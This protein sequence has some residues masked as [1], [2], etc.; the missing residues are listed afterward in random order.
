MA[1]SLFTHLLPED[2]ERYLEETARVLKPG[3]RFLATFYLMNAESQRLTES[4]SLRPMFRF[5]HDYGD[6]RL[7]HPEKPERA[8]AYRED[9]V[10]QRFGRSGY[11][12][13]EVRYGRWSARSQ[14]LSWQDV[15][16]GQRL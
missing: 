8:V 11:A 12:V 7:S 5:A 4:G 6:Y 16:V 15:V 14:F 13:S 10:L 2:F 3:G 1:T 9:F